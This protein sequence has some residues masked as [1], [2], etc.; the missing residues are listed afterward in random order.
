MSCFPRRLALSALACLW[1]A[2]AAAPAFAQTETVVASDDFNRADETPFSTAG[3]WGRTIAGNYD[4]FSNLTGNHVTGGSQEGI[5][6][7]KGAGSFSNTSQFARATVVDSTGEP[8]LILLAG[9]DHSINMTWGPPGPGANKSVFIYWYANS[10]DQGVLTSQVAPLADGDVIEAVLDGGVLRAKVNGVV[11]ASV[12]NT[13]TIASGTPGFI[14]YLNPSLPTLVAGMDDWLAG[15]PV[16]FSLGGTI[17]EGG[18]GLAGVQVTATGGFTGTATTDPNGV[19]SMAGVPGNATSIVITPAL[20]GHH[21]TPLTQT[22]AGPVTGNV[23]GLDF[24]STAITTAVLTVNATHGSVTRNPDLS[25]YPL[26][27]VVTLTPVPDPDYAFAGWSGDVP[28]GHSGDNP[29]QVTMDQ[30]RTI[31]AAFGSASVTASDDFNR[32]NETPLV[33]GSNW[34]QAFAGASA[35]LVSQHVVGATNDAIYY[36]IG[37]GLFNNTQQFA[38]ARVVDASG[39]VGV[40]LLGAS[41]QG[42]IA[43]WHQGTLFLYWYSAG[44]YRGNLATLPSNLSNGD[45][46]EAELSNGTVA[47]K[48]NGIVV[49]SV[50]NTTTLTAGN[51]GFE[52]FQSG[53]ILD[54]WQAGT[55]FSF[56]ISGTIL[57]SGAGLGGAFVSA[58][59]GFI[60]TA[61]TAP[62]GGYSL[63]GIPLNSTSIVLTPSAS[64]HNITPASR[65]VDGPVTA[66]VTGQDFT[67]TPAN[68]TLTTFATH[69]SVQ[70]SPDSPVYPVGTPVSLTAVPDDGYAFA[71]WSGDVPVGHETDNPLQVTMD[72]NRKINAIFVRPGVTAADYFNRPNE[73]PLVVGGNWVQPFTG[74]RSNLAGQQVAG[75][76]DEALYYWQGLGAFNDGA[77]FARARVVDPSGQL[78]LVLLGGAGQALVV[79]WHQGTLFI[80]WYSSGTYR[81]NLITSPSTISPGDIVEA[82]LSNGTVAAKINGTVVLSVPNSTTLTSGRPGFETFQS[83]GI[84]DDW[85][86]GTPTSFVISG[87]ILENGSGLGGVVVTATGGYTGSA[88]TLTNGVYS[89]TGVPPN[90]TAIILTPS[91]SGHL[92]SPASRSVDGP[93]TANIGGQDFTSSP[94]NLALTTSASHGAVQRAPDLPLYPVGSTVTL[95]PVPDFGYLFSGWS[96]AVPAGH[97]TDNP[98][99]VMMDQPRA[100]QALFLRPSVTAAEYFDRPNEIPLVTGGSWAAPFANGAAYLTNGHI[101]G[102]FGEA[103]YYWQGTGTFSDTQQYARA[104]VVDPSGQLGLVL[105]GGPGQA[106]VTAWHNGTLFV[107]WYSQSTYR[108]NLTTAPSTISAGDIIEADLSNGIISVM[109]NGHPVLS[110]A[111]TTTLTSGKPGFETFQSGGIIDDWESG[112]TGTTPIGVFPYQLQ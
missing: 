109:I 84:L 2:F 102:G 3:N 75:G 82:E 44:A 55:P 81:G 18:V 96:G 105:L 100:I 86:A 98:L 80:Y 46:I 25:P 95:T 51:P 50:L 64:G 62:N 12:A 67:S 39:Q 48:V 52:T 41:G 65:S 29:L 36:W 32:P 6:Y 111:N 99:Q 5:Y 17:T 110:V 47:A 59:G 73:I 76:I 88:V 57:E 103:V 24:T 71:G 10:Q 53:G 43:S 38:R 91:A 23:G 9:A 4:G 40:V 49:L 90:A 16:S 63:T 22:V 58:S 42:L 85:E 26:G 60:G 27:T 106:I 108:G 20:A 30:D 83:G 37:A 31:T 94:A 77:Q 15:T 92:M 56:A 13:T 14:T 19:W 93:V 8:G 72:Q 35:N 21:M 104:R 33:L 69:G 101:G 107:Y 70:R 89:L 61:V 87:T 79:S 78:G 45:V 68:A 54:D 74:G 112:T 66:N 34:A 28:P 97:E 1:A 7:W 11:V